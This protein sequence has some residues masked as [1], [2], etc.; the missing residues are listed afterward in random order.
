MKTQ[1]E[2]FAAKTTKKIEEKVPSNIITFQTLAKMEYL[3]IWAASRTFWVDFERYVGRMFF[4][5][6]GNPAL[7]LGVLK[8]SA[9]DLV[10]K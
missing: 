2:L 1:S 4:A 6:P 10:S 8:C 9:T 7:L 3:F 5:G